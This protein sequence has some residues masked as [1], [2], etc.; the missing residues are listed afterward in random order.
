MAELVDAWDLK[1]HVHC[2]RTGS[3]P[4]RATNFLNYISMNNVF[5]GQDGLTSTS[6]N[7][8]ANIAKE[9]QEAAA[10]RL[11]NLRFFNT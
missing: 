10:E 7:Y 4:V 8:Y 3:I 5:F 11:N 2:G 1:S 6:A 9:L